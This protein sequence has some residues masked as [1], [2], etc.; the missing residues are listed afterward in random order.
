VIANASPSNAQYSAEAASAAAQ[1][2]PFM[3][4]ARW[5]LGL[6][7][8][9]QLCGRCL[10]GLS[11]GSDIPVAAFQWLASCGGSKCGRDVLVG[12]QMG[13][14]S[15]PALKLACGAGGAESGPYE[16]LA[17]AQLLPRCYKAK[18]WRGRFLGACGVEQELLHR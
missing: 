6:Q 4:F 5:A 14:G 2:G 15:P 18:K 3:G 7:M 12:V 11:S 17:V 13:M 1:S 10:D 16:G 9:T 8:T